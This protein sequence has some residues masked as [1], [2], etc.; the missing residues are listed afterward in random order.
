MLWHELKT[1]IKSAAS[2]TIPHK[3]ISNEDRNTKPASLVSYYSHLKKLNTIFLKIRT[4][5]IIHRSWPNEQE[6]HIDL[7]TIRHTVSSLKLPTYDLPHQLTLDNIKPVRKYLLT[8]TKMLY[9]LA[10][11][12]EQRLKEQTI[13]YN[14]N[15]RQ[16]ELYSA[17]GKMIQSI[18]DNNK[19]KIVLDRLLVSTSQNESVLITDP[20]E[21][22]RNVNKH[23]QNFAIPS[24]PASALSGKWID[25]YSPKSDIDENIY[26][27]VMDP[28]DFELWMTTVNDLPNDKAPGPSGICNEMLKHLG[29]DTQKILHLLISFCFLTNDIPTEWKIAHVYPIPKPTEWDCDISKTRP[30]TLLECP[31]KAMVK[32]INQRLSHILA[33]HH[34]LKGNNFAGLPGGTTEDPIRIINTLIEDAN[35][36]KKQ[37]WILMQD[38]SKAYDRVDLKILKLAL[39]RIK[40]PTPCI[41]L[42]INLFTNRRNAVFTAD[43][44]SDL[45]DV[46]IGIDQGEVISPL[47]WCIYFD[48][49]LCEVDK[50]RKGYTLQ[51]SWKKDV[52]S[53]DV[54]TLTEM[55]S[56]LAYMDDA[57]WISDSKE[58]LEAQLAIADEFY[59]LTKS[60]INKDKSELLTTTKHLPTPINLKFGENYIPISPCKT[61][62]R[63]LGVWINSTNSPQFVKQQVRES[64]DSFTSLLNRKMIDS[65]QAIYIINTVLLPRITYKLLNTTL[66]ENECNKLSTN[67][68]CCVKHKSH[69]SKSAPDC[70]FQ[71]ELFYALDSLWNLQ[72]RALSASLLYQFNSDSLYQ[73]TSIIRLFTLQ[74]QHLLPAS[75]LFLWPF[76]YNQRNAHKTNLIGRTISLVSSTPLKISFALSPLLKNIIT[77]GHTAIAHLIPSSTYISIKA[78]AARH[79]LIF[80]EQLI[81]ATGQHLW[82]W[83]DFFHILTT[84][85]TTAVRPKIMALIEQSVLDPGFND[86]TLA[87]EYR[88]ENNFSSDSIPYNKT[89][90]HNRIDRIDL[91]SSKSE[92]F[93]TLIDGCPE[94]PYIGHSIRKLVHRNILI[95]QHYIYPD[96]QPNNS[97][98]VTPC[99]GCRFNDQTALTYIKSG[100]A[101]VRRFSNRL[102]IQCVSEFNP[103]NLSIVSKKPKK[104][105]LNSANLVSPISY[106]TAFQKVSNEQITQPSHEH[107]SS[108]KYLRQPQPD[109][110]QQPPSTPTSLIAELILDETYKL[111]LNAIKHN[112][113]DLTDLEFY[114]D[115]SLSSNGTSDCVMG[116]GWL[117]PSAND[118]S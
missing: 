49:L 30:I 55:I 64:I 4:K 5:H 66:S 52:N 110:T 94:Q 106:D 73:R 105:K 96:T 104:S 32:I 90:S 27:N 17:P 13:R 118:I 24:T 15:K 48:P 33:S 8:I 44:L 2:K 81:D 77:G 100:K 50:L 41:T 51:H 59:T 109:I 9:K 80:L 97:Y 34:I 62:T 61:S 7:N 26:D 70:I 84:R 76:K 71:C 23:F 69:F 93:C 115:G 68:R 114:S 72:L 89:L 25:Q 101:E 111:Q 56:S 91:A 43:G 87:I 117:C 36:K 37:I 46:K 75:P 98:E 92:L 12:E 10:K 47:L 65:N 78:V 53:A 22:K 1:I 99:T 58:H 74:S 57:T 38:L 67:I 54:T 60:A 18:L 29:T 31:R 45:Y 35:E 82:S 19:K 95:A 116:I 112:L 21:I 39:S 6:W 86:R 14:I 16:K 83:Q 108:V 20:A 88:I 11:L 103:T 85:T 28:P 42:I 79:N 40:I 63:Y 107:L 102:D 3:R 113:K